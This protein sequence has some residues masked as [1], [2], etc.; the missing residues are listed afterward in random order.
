[1]N[2][3]WQFQRYEQVGSV[4]FKREVC[5]SCPVGCERFTPKDKVSEIVACDVV[6]VS[7]KKI[8]KSLQD[9]F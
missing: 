9:F 5:F 8:S 2:P 6:G 4:I 1:M 3:F 7:R